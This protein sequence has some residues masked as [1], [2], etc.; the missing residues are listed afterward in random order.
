MTPE[1]ATRGLFIVFFIFN[2]ISGIAAVL[3]F[4]IY[5]QVVRRTSLPNAR[6]T[7]FRTELLRAHEEYFPKSTAR[8]FGRILYTISAVLMVCVGICVVAWA[9]VKFR[10]T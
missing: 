5:L 8:T 4:V 10:R 6:L 3:H 9:A 7:N 2:I 1:D